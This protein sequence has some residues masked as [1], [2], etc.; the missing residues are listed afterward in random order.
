MQEREE[1]K[2]AEFV[3]L[4]RAVAHEQTKAPKFTDPTA[5]AFLSEEARASLMR[6]RA[7][8]TQASEQLV[9]YLVRIRSEVIV[10][11][12]MGSTSGDSCGLSP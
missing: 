9:H 11:R 5:V 10:A 8:A 12:T 1:S 2:T 3:C 4:A 7:G 6:L